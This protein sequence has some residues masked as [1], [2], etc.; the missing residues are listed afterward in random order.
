MDINTECK[1]RTLDAMSLPA[2]Q[3]AVVDRLIGK[4]WIDPWKYGRSV[5]LFLP[6]VWH[7]RNRGVMFRDHH[8]SPIRVTPT[9]RILAGWNK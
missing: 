5:Y 6:D 1:R 8:R 9:G 7:K 2:A 4:G 3:L